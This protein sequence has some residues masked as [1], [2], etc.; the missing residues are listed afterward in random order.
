ML[1]DP[2]NVTEPHKELRFTRSGQG[3]RFFL[4][5]AALTTLAIF[6]AAAAFTPGLEFPLWWSTLPLLP[7][8]G[9]FFIAYRCVRF[10]YLLLTPLGV[11][12]FPFTKSHKNLQVIYWSEIAHAEV[13]PDRSLLILHYNEEQTAG[14]KASLRPLAAAQRPLLARAIKGRMAQR[15]EATD[16]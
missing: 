9:L 10:A 4:A 2:Q 15:L 11:E 5:A 13:S 3:R 16:S 12:I 7:A 6:L 1:P 8:I 14:I